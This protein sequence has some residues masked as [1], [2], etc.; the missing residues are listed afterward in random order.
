[1]AEKKTAKKEKKE[2]RKVD[3]KEILGDIKTIVSGEKETLFK[4]SAVSYT[5]L[6]LPTTPYV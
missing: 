2:N 4:V 6:T 5:H 3:L 1:M